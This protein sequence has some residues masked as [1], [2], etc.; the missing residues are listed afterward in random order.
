MNQEAIYHRL[1]AAQKGDPQAQVDCGAHYLHGEHQD[2]GRAEYWFRKA[3]EQGLPAG[4][5]ALA[6]VLETFRK[7]PQE[8]LIWLRRAVARS[9]PD[10][11][12]RMAVLGL[13][14][15]VQ[16][17][18]D[19]QALHYLQQASAQ[20]HAEAAELAAFCLHTGWGGTDNP[21]GAARELM[22]ALRHGSLAARIC[23]AGWL[24]QG[25][26]L[27]AEPV[28]V[29]RAWLEVARH[30]PQA[31]AEVRRVTAGLSEAEQ[32][33]AQRM[34]RENADWPPLRQLP[35]PVCREPLLLREDPPAVE[36]PALAHP[37]L[38]ANWLVKYWRRPERS[39]WH[40]PRREH[41]VRLHWLLQQLTP[42]LRL[43]P[44]RCAG[45]WLGPVAQVEQ[46]TAE[47]DGP[48]VDVLLLAQGLDRSLPVGTVRIQSDTGVRW[49]EQSL[50][51]RLEYTA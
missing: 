3:A 31:M 29:L 21:V 47:G 33:L 24:E 19:V 30:R 14:R 4:Q 43:P 40:L 41:S 10:A 6:Y 28:S 17:V 44:D 50:I 51:A 38:C 18:R 37:L 13:C 49:Q 48:R 2:V 23:L 20:G 35:A 8:A 1:L 7:R 11:L 27:E 46:A 32:Q 42:R 16:E 25:Q 45:L 39:L 36:W 34:A 5:T 12:Y 15:V 9:H 26:G 22:A